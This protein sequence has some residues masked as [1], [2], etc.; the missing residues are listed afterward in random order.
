[1]F[2]VAPVFLFEPPLCEFFRLYP[3]LSRLNISHSTIFTLSDAFL[4]CTEFLRNLSRDIDITN[5]QVD[6]VDKRLHSLKSAG[7][8]LHH[9]DDPIEALGGRVGESRVREGKDIV[10][11]FPERVDKLAQRFE[12]A[13]E[14]GGRPL[15]Q[16]ALRPPGC[17]IIPEL[18]ELVLQHPS[19]VDP[20]VTL[21]QLI[22][23]PR[24]GFGAIPGM[25]E[26]QP[27]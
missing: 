12:S 4:D 24:L 19:A 3:N 23:Y 26:Q 7:T 8:I 9:P 14:G 27:T 18:I 21:A 10:D 20:A 16:K 17:L 13:L 15:L 25:R 6:Q 2:A 22:K 5:D 11:M 1:M